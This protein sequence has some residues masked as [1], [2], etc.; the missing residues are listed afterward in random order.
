MKKVVLVFFGLL[1]SCLFIF[2]FWGSSSHF[3]SSK[4]NE[5]KVYHANYKSS[6]DT[7][8]VVTYN[9]GYLSG[10][11]NNLAV[12]RSEDLF[13]SNLTRAIA[14]LKMQQADFI[15]FQEIDFGSQRSFYYQQLDSLGIA[16]KY[17]NA[18]SAV[19][20]DKSYVP[21]PY[22]PIKFHF[23]RMLSGQAIL[24]KMQIVENYF[25]TL[26]KPLSAP[27]YYNQFYLERLIQISK[28]EI[29]DREV[30][31]MNVHLEAFDQETRELQARYL[32]K[33]FAKYAADFPVL[34]MGDFNAESSFATA[35]EKPE[36]S[37]QLF[38]DHPLIGMAI[39]K[40]KYLKDES[41]FFTFDSRNPYQ[42]ID[43]IF[44]TKHSIEKIDAG[45]FQEAGDISDHLPVWM[46]FR[47]K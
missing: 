12:D 45:V 25:I 20:W 15:G 19:N 34:L 31:L 6:D 17:P 42:K 24:S 2:Y 10:M 27:F 26:E 41:Q 39:S 11:S 16:L 8:K 9:I 14:L 5:I 3:P 7:L 18:A 40:E 23:G 32:L 35:V 38:T 30:I 21:F 4:Y 46:T 36:S 37:I 28:V 22:W 44:Y 33:E 13:R 29:N 47:W 1:I 43:Y